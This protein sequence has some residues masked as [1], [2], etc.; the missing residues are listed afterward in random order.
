MGLVQLEVQ[1][2]KVESIVA[3]AAPWAVLW[4]T[5]HGRP[6]ATPSVKDAIVNGISSAIDWI[7]ALPGEAIQW[8]KDMIQGFIDGIKSMMSIVAST[9]SDVGNTIRSFFHFSTPD[10]GPLVDYEKWMPD[11][12]SGLATGI[13][14]NKSKVTQ[15]IQGLSND[16]KFNVNANAS[17]T[18]STAGSSAGAGSTVN[19]S[20]SYGALL[21]TDKIVVSN[22]MDIQTL[23]NKLEFYRGQMAKA[24]E[25]N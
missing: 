18:P 20:Y 15:A 21:H 7:T 1:F 23:A 9:I 13:E 17:L 2:G 11:F 14:K 3:G 25:S 12:M 6:P 5:P 16:M 22:N 10:Q 8:G 4:V 24:K 19:N